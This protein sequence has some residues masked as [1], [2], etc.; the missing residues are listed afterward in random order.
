MTMWVPFNPVS[1]PLAGHAQ[2]QAE[3]ADN[4]SPAAATP[5]QGS[6]SESVAAQEAKGGPDH[7]QKSSP[8]GGSDEASKPASSEIDKLK[9]EL[10][11]MQKRIENL[12]QSE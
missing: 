2:G 1:N 8:P 10:A 6:G 9:D 4:A 5:E 12:S 7:G 11:A 3:A